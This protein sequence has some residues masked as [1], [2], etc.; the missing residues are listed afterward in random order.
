MLR[1]LHHPQA[2]Q[3]D[4][5]PR[6]LQHLEPRRE[7]ACEQQTKIER[8]M[9]TKFREEPLRKA[10]LLSS[11]TCH[12]SP[13]TRH[14]SSLAS[15]ILARRS[16]SALPITDTELKLIAAAASIGL[17]RIPKNGYRTPAASGTPSEL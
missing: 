11:V 9:E 14:P 13:V 8:M 1:P 15:Q 12:P 5:F 4:Q 16:R 17:R 3:A 2:T 10:G 6:T 7:S